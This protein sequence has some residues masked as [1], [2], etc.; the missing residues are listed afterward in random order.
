ML[1][2]PY[3]ELVR[4]DMKRNYAFVQFKTVDEAIRAK[5]ATNGGKLDQSEI[6]IEF[7]ARRMGE[8]GGGGRG[9]G[10]RRPR[11]FDD[12]GGGYRGGGGGR[13]DC[14]GRDGEY[15]P[16]REEYRPRE[17]GGGYRVGRYDDEG[18]SRRGGGGGGGG[19]G[20]G[21]YRS[22]RGSDEY[23]PSSRGGRDSYEDRER[24]ERGYGRAETER[25]EGRY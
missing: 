11:R 15:R 12:R 8:G 2:E 25:P 4:I 1:F 16:R 19:Y 17:G 5:E 14:G 3:G 10:E 18:G 23:R 24:V 20:G 21:D 7:V 9:D 22:S 13:G 6:T